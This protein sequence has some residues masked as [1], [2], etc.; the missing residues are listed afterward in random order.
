MRNLLPGEQPGEQVSVINR[1]QAAMVEEQAT[2]CL[3]PSEGP[4]WGQSWGLK[5]LPPAA[6]VSRDSCRKD[7]QYPRRILRFWTLCGRETV[8]S[9]H[10]YL[11]SSYYVPGVLINRAQ[12][13]ISLWDIYDREEA[14]AVNKNIVAQ[15]IPISSSLI[16][17]WMVWIF[18]L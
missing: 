7:V 6:A 11:F 10:K 18:G 9:L 16:L 14:F 17:P 4:L 3:L 8:H 5:S 12:N 1:L 15:W 13:F 2:S